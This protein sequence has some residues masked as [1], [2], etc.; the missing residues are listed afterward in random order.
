MPRLQGHLLRTGGRNHPP[1]HSAAH[2]PALL[3]DVQQGAADARID[4]MLAT[5][6]EERLAAREAEIRGAAR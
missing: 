3:T 6:L 2:N 1:R 4:A 5:P